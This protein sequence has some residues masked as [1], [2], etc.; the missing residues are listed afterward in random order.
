MS[1]Q[2]KTDHKEMTHLCRSV[3]YYYTKDYQ[4][5]LKEVD[6]ALQIQPVSAVS[7]ALKKSLSAQDAANFGVVFD[8]YVK[9]QRRRYIVSRL[10]MG[11]MP[12]FIKQELST[13]LP[14]N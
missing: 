7:M 14:A 10:R 6:S 12:E 4:N 8:S 9:L 1:E 2:K 13:M 5:A 3:V 11:A